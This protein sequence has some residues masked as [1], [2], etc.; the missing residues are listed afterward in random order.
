M[1]RAVVLFAVPQAAAGKTGTCCLLSLRLQSRCCCC[2]LRHMQVLEAINL[3]LAG[4]GFAVVVGMVSALAADGHR[5]HANPARPA[6]AEHLS[7]HVPTCS[8]TTGQAVCH[9]RHPKLLQGRGGDAE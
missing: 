7:L 9:Q 3:V 1:R 4:A 6:L 2:F 8:S 5:V